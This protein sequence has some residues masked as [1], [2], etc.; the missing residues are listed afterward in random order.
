MPLF[1]G[2]LS[3]V[4][5]GDL[6]AVRTGGYRSPGVHRMATSSV[7]FSHHEYTMRKPPNAENG[8]WVV[9]VKAVH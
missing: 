1:R 3:E 7:T 9:R 4:A 6:A 2:E 5:P 8:I